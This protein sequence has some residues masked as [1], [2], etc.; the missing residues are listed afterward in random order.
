MIVAVL[1]LVYCACMIGLHPYDAKINDGVLVLYLILMRGIGFFMITILLP[2][3]KTYFLVFNL[4]EIPT[5]DVI[6]SLQAI[7]DD[8]DAC[9]YFR[10]FMTEQ[11]SQY[12]LDFWMEIDLFKDA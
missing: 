3:Y 5:Q 8:M 12:L 6:T 1:D 9:V 10:Q 2:L 11:D 4:P 7:L